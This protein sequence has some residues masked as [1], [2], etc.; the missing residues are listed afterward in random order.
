MA[1]NLNDNALKLKNAILYDGMS[2][3]VIKEIY[4]YPWDEN[5]RHVIFEKYPVKYPNDKDDWKNIKNGGDILTKIKEY[6]INILLE[7][8]MVTEYI[9]LDI[10]IKPNGKIENDE[11]D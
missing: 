6:K 9:T 7:P 4:F 8:K 5:T 1:D 2:D 3:Y 10:T 11:L